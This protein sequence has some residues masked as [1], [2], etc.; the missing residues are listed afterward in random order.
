MFMK[1]VEL[2]CGTKSFSKVAEK[3]GHDVFTVDIDESFS[4]SLAKNILDMTAKDIPVEFHNCDVL[5][6]SPPC[7]C[8][9]VASIGTN[10]T[11][12]KGA[13][14][15]KRP[16][17]VEAIQILRKTLSL[18]DE[19]K[20]KSWFIENPVGVMRKMPEMQRLPRAT[21]TYCQ[22]GDTRMKP[23]DVWNNSKT[24]NPRPKCRNGAP[25]HERAPRG[26][27]TGTQGL[28]TAKDR[29][30]VPEQLCEEILRACI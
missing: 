3:E 11:G 2:F 16:E 23:T 15:P 4:P 13:Y 9:S 24:W 5:W 12:G 17:A 29:S 6:A 14:I 25:C 1:V 22:Y 28:K 18:I 21:V 30:R 10:W 26:A 19:L 20:P 27:K 8:F 7:T